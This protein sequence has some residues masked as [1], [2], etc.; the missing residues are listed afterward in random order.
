MSPSPT[1][2]TCGPVVVDTNILVGAGFNPHSDSARLVTAIRD[3]RLRMIWNDA[4]RRETE[5]I[6]RRIP[7]LSWAEISDI[8]RESD[9][10]RGVVPPEHQF[11]HVGDASDRKFVALACAA[12]AVLATND[13]L[14]LRSLA[15]T[16]VRAVRPGELVRECRL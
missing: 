4:T 9:R 10:F 14:L 8:F 16:S 2:A 3:G 7:R 13:A 15:Q 6:L 5:Y 12:N 11:G 1:T